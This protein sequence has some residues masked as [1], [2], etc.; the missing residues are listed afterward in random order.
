[1]KISDK[2]NMRTKTLI[3]FTFAI[4]TKLVAIDRFSQNEPIFKTYIRI[5]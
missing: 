4:T 5:D 3:A 1:M 2:K